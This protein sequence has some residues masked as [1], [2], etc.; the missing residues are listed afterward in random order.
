VNRWRAEQKSKR[1]KR[2][3]S[4]IGAVAGLV[5]AWACRQWPNHATCIQVT[6]LSFAVLGIVAWELWSYRRKPRFIG[7]L[8]LVA[9]LHGFV[10]YSI[11]SMLPFRSGLFLCALLF[12]ECLAALIVVLKLVDES[13]E[14]PRVF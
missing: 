13:N 8:V 5:A 7:G 14:I 3:S 1:T 2:K 6:F 11:R 12:F 10:L 9:V 4:V